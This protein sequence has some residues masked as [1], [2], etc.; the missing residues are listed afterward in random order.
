M[1]SAESDV[2]ECVRRQQES[3]FVYFVKNAC[4][5]SAR[6]RRL[7]FLTTKKLPEKFIFWELVKEKER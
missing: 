5:A 1:S 7:F 2:K 4:L 6:F 3:K